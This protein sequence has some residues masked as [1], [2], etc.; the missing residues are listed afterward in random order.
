MR[1]ERS[2]LRW[3]FL[4]VFSLFLVG[5]LSCAGK[6]TPRDGISDPGEMIYNGFAVPDVKC[7]SCH[8]ADGRGT[9]REANL[10]ESVP[11]MTDQAIAN[12]IEEGPGMM[13]AFKDKLDSQQVASLTAWLRGRF[14]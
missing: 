11:K 12:A 2:P 1:Q 7:Y 3:W 8:N 13:P 9:W 6:Q 4:A 14:R 10:A 5:A